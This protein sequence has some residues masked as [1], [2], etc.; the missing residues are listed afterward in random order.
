MDSMSLKIEWFIDLSGRVLAEYNRATSNDALT[1]AGSYAYFAAVRYIRDILVPY[2][3]KPSPEGGLEITRNDI[4]GIA[5]V[6]SSGNEH[7]GYDKGP[8]PKTKNPKGPKTLNFLNN[9]VQL[10]LWPEMDKKVVVKGENDEPIWVYL[11]HIDKRKKEIRSELSL[12]I[13]M[14][15]DRLRVSRWR[16]RIILPSVRFGIKPTPPET[17]Y[18]EDY[19]PELNFEI[20]RRG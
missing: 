9:N 20:K 15:Y 14:S 8:E 3:W 17:K 1:A 18:R 13:E 6:V 12:P 10:S 4:T 7:T 19:T 11:Y 5:I 16:S 2:G